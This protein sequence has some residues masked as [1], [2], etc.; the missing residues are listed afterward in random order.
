LNSADFERSRSRSRS[1]TEFDNFSFVAEEQDFQEE[2][3]NAHWSSE[4]SHT[5]DSVSVIDTDDEEYE[6]IQEQFAQ[7]TE[8]PFV[9]EVPWHATK[10]Y[11]KRLVTFVA[12]ANFQGLREF[13]LQ[14]GDMATLY[15]D[16]GMLLSK[17]GFSD[18]ALIFYTAIVEI[19]FGNPVNMRML[20]YK[21]EQLG[22]LNYAIDLFER[23][24]RL[25]Y[26]YLESI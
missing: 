8:R 9:R 14:Q 16:S 7:V 26:T 2:E 10:D 6:N 23:V 24:W 5:F 13:C 3:F 1:P 11:Y 17:E 19:D 20:A 15:L 4:C 21:M 12:G 18:E 25:R 22:Y